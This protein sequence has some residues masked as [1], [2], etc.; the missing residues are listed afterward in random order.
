MRIVGGSA[1]GRAIAGPK[2]D[3][4]RP[5][6]DR[7]RETLFNILGQ[8]FDGERVLDLFAGTGALAL[9]ALSRGAS[10]AMLVD[11]DRDSVALC[12]ENAASLGF[13]DLVEVRAAKADRAVERLAQE[14]RRFEL[15]FADP[16]YALTACVKVVEWAD[17]LSL[18][19]DGGTLILEHDKR[20]ILPET[21]GRLFRADERAFGDTRIS[22]YRFAAAGP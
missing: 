17:S 13:S 19:A 1:R 7:V 3:G 4:V 21:S 16:P 18:L 15:I 22:L 2:H 10:A 9:E 12:L 6:A 11:S 8:T 14:G 20:E 5:T